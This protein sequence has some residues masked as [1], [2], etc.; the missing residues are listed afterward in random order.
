MNQAFGIRPKFQ[1]SL[2]WWLGFEVARSLP[3]YPE[4]EQTKTCN[5]PAPSNPNHHSANFTTPKA[6][7]RDQVKDLLVNSTPQSVSSLIGRS[8]K[9]YPRNGRGH[10]HSQYWTRDM[11]GF[12]GGDISHLKLRQDASN[13]GILP[14]PWFLFVALGEFFRIPGSPCPAT[15]FP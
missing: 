10:F 11:G 3:I 7:F 6:Q 1:H 12:P 14:Y 9:A 2:T 5:S 13:G 4:Q 15:W 8:T